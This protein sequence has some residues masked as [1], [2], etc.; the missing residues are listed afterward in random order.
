MGILA[1]LIA[2]PALTTGCGQWSGGRTVHHRPATATQVAHTVPTGE[3]P[4]YHYPDTPPVLNTNGLRAFVGRFRH[5][6]VLLDFWALRCRRSLSEMGDIAA[7]QTRLQEDGFQVVSCNLDDAARWQTETV[8]AL[9]EVGASFPCVVISPG[10]KAG[11][12]RWL[13]PDWSYDLPARFLVDRRGRVVRQVLSDEPLTSMTGQARRLVLWGGADTNRARLPAGAVGL[14]VT[15]VDV[16]RGTGESLSE[17]IADSADSRRLAEVVVNEIATKIDRSGNPR[18][19]VLP[20][21]RLRGGRS[22]GRLG[23]QAARNVPTLLRA[24]GY[25]DVVGPDGTQRMIDEAAITA[26]A[27]EFDPSQVQGRLACDYLIVGWLREGAADAMR[28]RRLAAQ[29]AAK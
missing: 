19:A 9:Q 26:L 3:M 8:P 4:A 17:V 28:K 14:R 20:F 11:V 5:R 29:V 23:D 25:Y 10:A 22:A 12:R 6:V 15:L 16:R 7:L 1:L 27:I 2:L 18:I 24:R 13:A 21:G